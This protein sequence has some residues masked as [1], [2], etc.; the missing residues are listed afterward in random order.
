MSFFDN[1]SPIQK[2]EKKT[3]F[4]QTF[5]TASE[6]FLSKKPVLIQSIIFYY[7]KKTNILSSCLV[8]IVDEALI[9]SKV[10]YNFYFLT[11]PSL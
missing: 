1:P 6:E 5:S 4:F 2:N 9:I 8:S 10:P 3:S 7:K 11:F